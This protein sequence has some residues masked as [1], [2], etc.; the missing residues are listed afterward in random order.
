MGTESEQPDMA[1]LA[2]AGVPMADAVKLCEAWALAHPEPGPIVVEHV[3]NLD[4]YL[5][6]VPKAAKPAKVEPVEEPCG[7]IWALNVLHEIVTQIET[8]RADPTQ[9]GNVGLTPSTAK[10][11]AYYIRQSKGYP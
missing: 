1:A 3:L 7:E 10:E 6:P 2:A 5:P 9:L 4:C 8:Q 11:I